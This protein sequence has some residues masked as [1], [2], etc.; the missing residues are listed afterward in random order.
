MLNFISSKRRDQ[1]AGSWA[2]KSTSGAW[3]KGQTS[4][5]DC[6]SFPAMSFMSDADKPLHGFLENFGGCKLRGWTGTRWWSVDR[7]TYRAPHVLMHSCGAVSFVVLLLEC[8]VTHWRPC[9]CMA[10]D[11][12]ASL[13]LT[14]KNFIYTSSSSRHVIHLAEPDTTHEHSILT[15]SRNSLP[16]TWPTSRRSMATAE[17]RPDGTITSCRLWAQPDC[18]RS[19]WQ[20]LHRRRS[21]HWTR[22][23]TCQTLVLRQ[24]DHSITLWLSG[25]HRNAP[26]IGLSRRTTSCSA[27]FTTVLTGARS[28]CRT[29]A[30]LS[31]WTRRWCPVHPKMRHV[32]GNLSQCFQAR[33]GWIKT[34]FP[35]ETIFP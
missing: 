25:K 4:A 6:I 31:L 28:K 12:S 10:Q 17:W 27:G 13:C 9:T 14:S 30:S 23:C 21:V 33:I 22:V 16:A 18:W 19:G 1:E 7:H 11:W 2:S 5:I 34:H 35:K 24:V 26:G 20:A 3:H 32:Q 8:T 15:F 29:I